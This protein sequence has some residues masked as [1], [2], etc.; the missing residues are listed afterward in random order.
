MLLHR[1]FPDIQQYR[2]IVKLIKNN[3]AY[4]GKDSEGNALYDHSIRCPI[5]KY[6]GTVKLHGTNA[7][8]CYNLDTKEMYCQSRENIITPQSDNAGFAMYIQSVRKEVLSHFEY[9]AN[10]CSYIKPYLP[11]NSIN[12]T[13]VI[14][15][16]WCGGSIQKGIAINQLSKMFVILNI[17]IADGEQNRTWI[18]N[19]D[20]ILIN[21]ILMKDGN[22]FKCI[23]DFENWDIDI[24][25]EDPL[26]FQNKLSDLTIVVE[27]ECPVGKR[28]G[29]TSEKGSMIG[30]GIVW[31]CIT[32]GYESSRYWFKVKGE[33][34]QKSRVKTLKKI[35]E[36]K[37]ARVKEVV[38][39]VC[40]D[41]RLEQM[42]Q[43]TFDT[44]NGGQLDITKMGAFIKA[45]MG[46]IFK[47]EVDTIA[48]SGL[49]G[50]DISAPVA[51]KCREYLNKKLN[52]EAG[53]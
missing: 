11:E 7:A 14:F 26:S 46:D 38:E 52:E 43:S 32:L 15:G 19:E 49:V 50:K 12:T 22:W 36:D 16:E 8:V 45:V 20:L 29:A 51:S 25:F 34:H 6:N 21:S 53:L 30:E 40:P 27:E 9:L 2:N 4:I 5:L 31:K 17:C 10:D 44:L 28:L 48:E 24:D 42:L 1:K 18:K 39:V 47:E 33:K 23:T 3:T 41:W 37:L 35:D 13:M